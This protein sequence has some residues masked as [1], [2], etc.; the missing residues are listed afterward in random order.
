MRQLGELIKRQ[1]K[2]LAALQTDIERLIDAQLARDDPNPT[3]EETRTKEGLET[4]MRDMEADLVKNR[5]LEES[6]ARQA[7]AKA[8]IV[9]DPIDTED[10]FKVVPRK[11]EPGQLFSRYVMAVAASRGNLVQA[12]E[13][14]HR[15]FVDTP[16]IEKL[17]RAR[18]QGMPSIISKAA[19][20][21]AGTTPPDWAGV[22]VYAQNMASEFIEYL[23]PF[24]IIPRVNGLRR[25]PFN[26]RI[27]RQT[28]GITQTTWVGEGTPKP[29]GRFAL[30]AV[31]LPWAKVACI[32]ALT[33]ELM[34]FS[35]PSAELLIRDE[36]ANA[37]AQFLDGQ[38]IDR[39][40]APVAGTK[41]GSITNGIPAGNVIPST[42]NAVDQI[43]ADLNAA[44]NAL[45]NVN[46]P[47]RA[48][49]WL[50]SSR[51][52]NYLLSQRVSLGVPAWPSLSA[53][54]TLLGHP[55]VMSNN[56]PINL[57]VGT[58]ES[59][60]ILVEASEILLADDGGIT[61]DVSNEASLQMVDTPVAGA[62]TLV[63]LWQNNLIGLKAERYIFWMRR[64]DAA[65]A[66]ITGVLY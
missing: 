57:G 60:I 7:V 61:V 10:Y 32:V 23:R 20:P 46:I 38:F 58:N 9:V 11:L 2:D 42:G 56:I 43:T 14:A 34:R 37:M 25:V 29:V 1:Q 31:I 26:I 50:M 36:L 12:A 30:D 59:E 17:L 19:V 35:D 40:V 47:D 5:A 39:T 41:P 62:Q 27:P 16:G 49:S 44:N 63:S 55:V 8:H 66:I 13:I 64:H 51:S 53:N 18:T 65:V 21:A 24:T 6:A 52:Y 3:E 45:S 22:L 48:R 15:H 28:S 4:R 33:E 54:G